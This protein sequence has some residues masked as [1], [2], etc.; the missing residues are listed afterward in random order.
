VD[1]RARLTTNFDQGVASIRD[2]EINSEF[3]FEIRQN[4][5]A[6]NVTDEQRPT[7]VITSTFIV[8]D[9]KVVDC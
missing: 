5:V 7:P 2:R 4:H 1:A 3:L 8:N 9:L 6:V